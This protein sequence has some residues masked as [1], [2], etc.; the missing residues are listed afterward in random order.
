MERPGFLIFRKLFKISFLYANT[1]KRLFRSLNV[2]NICTL[3]HIQYIVTDN[4][5]PEDPITLLEERGI[6]VIIA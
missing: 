1:Y 4:K 6:K 3:D 2:G 5:V